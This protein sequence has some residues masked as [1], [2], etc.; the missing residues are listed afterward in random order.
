MLMSKTTYLSAILVGALC[1]FTASAGTQGEDLPNFLAHQAIL[2][3]RPGEAIA[4]FLQDVPGATLLDSIPGHNIHLLQLPVGQDEDAFEL[5]AESDPRVAEAELNHENEASEG[6]T[7]SF[8]LASIHSAFTQQYTWDTIARPTIAEAPAG[9]GVLIAVL[10]TGVDAQHPELLGRVMPGFDFITATPDATDR[11]D[12]DDTDGDTL[13][14]EMVGHGTFMAGMISAVAPQ[15]DILPIRVLDGDGIGESFLITKAIFWAV[16]QGADVINMSFS[17]TA[18]NQ[19][20]GVAIEYAREQGV[21]FVAAAGNLNEEDPKQYPAA[22]SDVIGVAATN[23]DDLKSDFSNFGRHITIAAP[24][25]AIVGIAPG[26]QYVEWDGTSMASSLVAGAAAVIL[27]ANPG[28]L[29]EDVEAILI[30]GAMPLDE[31]NPAYAGLLGAGRLNIAA[32]LGLPKVPNDDGPICIGQL[33]GLCVGPFATATTAAHVSSVTV[34]QDTFTEPR[35]AQQSMLTHAQ[36]HPAP[37]PACPGDFTG[38]GLV[39]TEDLTILLGNF[40]D[41][42][43]P[44]SAGDLTGDARVTTADLTQ[45]LGAFGSDCR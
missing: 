5:F 15:S 11:G 33:A 13:V 40:G 12:G 39:T 4:D 2:E 38:D 17:T 41:A 44:G 16:D 19:V 28:A 27:S 14:D 37:L 1:T 22:H 30:G 18:E 25:T 29:P 45:F 43:V 7:Q 8:F 20:M 31:I 42:V 35:F 24:G 36:G 10:D 26:E 32:S 23:S 21:V 6:Q 9:N 34:T 3:L